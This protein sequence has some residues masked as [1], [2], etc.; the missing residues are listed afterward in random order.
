MMKYLRI[1]VAIAVFTFNACKQDETEPPVI[2]NPINAIISYSVE[3]QETDASISSGLNTQ[4][5]FITQNP[6]SRKDK[7]LIF[8]PGTQAQPSTYLK[9][10]KQL[11]KMAIIQLALII[12]TTSPLPIF[13]GI[14]TTKIVITMF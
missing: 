7:L 1:L 12:K 11:Q 4:F 6:S 14:R 2:E 8:L 5:A 13:V 3:P 10:C 9:F